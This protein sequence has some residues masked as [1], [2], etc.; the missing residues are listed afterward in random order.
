MTKPNAL[1]PL[2]PAD[3]LVECGQSFVEGLTFG[4]VMD[5]AHAARAPLLAEIE[6]LRTWQ[7]Q[8]VE[9]MAEEH[10][11]AGYRELANKCASLEERAEAAER[12]R[13]ALRKL[14]PLVDEVMCEHANDNEDNY[15]ACDRNQCDWCLQASVAIN[16]ATKARIAQSGD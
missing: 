1:P 10:D 14:I 6:K 9:K 4:L 7:R 8:M 13:D 16:E 15:R 12:E 3:L 2:P 5:Y 11:L